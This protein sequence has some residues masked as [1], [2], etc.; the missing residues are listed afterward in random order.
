MPSQSETNWRALHGNFFEGRRAL[1]TGGAGFIGSHV[2]DALTALGAQVR[3]I[4]DLS[5]SDGSNIAHL[6]N[7][8]LVKASILDE[9]AV[10]KAAQGCEFVFHLAAMVSVPASVER[11]RLYHDVNTTGTVNVLSAARDAKAKRV[12]FS[13]SS[14]AYG[15]SVELPKI[16]TMTPM[17][18]SPYAATK[19]AGEEYIR[20]YA[21]SYE[22][23]GVAL[24]YFNIFGPRQNANSAYAG[25]IAAFARMLLNGQN[26][27]ITGDGTATRD[28]TYVHNA[29][30]ANLLG[31]RHP[32]RLNGEVFNVATAHS[33][34]I[35]E[36]ATS[37]ARLINR[38]DL[39][40]KYLPP[41]AGDVMHSLADLTRSKRVL[42]YEP[43][44]TFEPG[45]KATLDWYQSRHS[46]R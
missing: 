31:A 15:D 41:R 27:T 10:N 5:G 32:Q 13:A 7:I 1:V 37:M 39:K 16:E 8:E 20:A 2:C 22:T 33:M 18:K 12:M 35:T 4:D 29:V 34:T 24:R 14:S 46:T 44:I 42:N 25:V 21:N 30:H 38:A 19:L 11:P 43:I 23:D 28:F 9:Q 6:K 45:L 26:P 3:V 36:L 40:P 17:P